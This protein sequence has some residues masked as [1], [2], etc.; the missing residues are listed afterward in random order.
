[1]WAV[2]AVLRV[3]WSPF[4]KIAVAVVALGLWTAYQRADATDDCVDAQLRAQLETANESLR[5][6]ASVARAAAEEAAA[7]LEDVSVLKGEKDALLEELER[8]GASCVLPDDVRE[9]L[10]RIK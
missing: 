5:K 1:M 10:L 4:G 6:A 9:R 8:R 3:I 7:A 2:S